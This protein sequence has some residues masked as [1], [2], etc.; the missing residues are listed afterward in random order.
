MKRCSCCKKDKDDQ[1]FIN[2]GSSPLKDD[3]FKTCID[4]R[5]RSR[6]YAHENEHKKKQKAKEHYVLNKEKIKKQ[7]KEWRAKNKKKLREYE[8]SEDRKIKCKKWRDKTRSLDRLRFIWYAAKRRAKDKNIIFKISKQDIADVYPSNGK[9]PMLG[10]ELK[11]DNN[12]SADNSP[13]LDRIV[14]KLGYIVGNIQ[15]ISYRA[16]RIKND[17]TIEELEK[18]LFF[19]KGL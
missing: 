4:C 15:V 12:K 7:N 11:I 8:R 19:L 18:I 9:C 10:I 14:P 3:Y 16:N 5:N 17:A 1:C 2:D 6:N 13:S